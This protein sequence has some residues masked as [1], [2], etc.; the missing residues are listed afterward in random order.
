MEHIYNENT[1]EH[2][3]SHSHGDS[4]G[5]MH[6]HSHATP[7]THDETLIC[8]EDFK[9]TKA[10][11]EYMIHHNEHHAEELADLLEVLPKKAQKK[12]TAAIGTFEAANVELQEV[13]ACLE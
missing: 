12:L 8:S 6:L 5:H 10:L 13:L 4:H 2:S 7:H 11:L 1:H 3:H 9:Q